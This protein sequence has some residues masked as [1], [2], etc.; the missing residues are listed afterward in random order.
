M[1]KT[2]RPILLVSLLSLLLVMAPSLRA[3]GH[4]EFSAHYGQWSLNLLGGLARDLISDATKS[5]IR[6]RIL[7]NIQGSYPGLNETSYNQTVRFDSS[8]H[9]FGFGVRFYPSRNGSFSLGVSV[10]QSTFKV[11]PSVTSQMGLQDSGT[12]QT[13]TFDGTAAASAVIKATAFLLTFRWDIF[14]RA[15]VHPYITFG[16]GITTAKAL[17]DSTLSYSYSGQL[18][19]GAVT[20]QTISGSDSKTLRQLKDQS[21]TKFPNFL[22]FLQLNFGLKAMVTK[23]IHLLVDAGVFDGFMISGGLAVRL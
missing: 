7:S 19:G 12:S 1:K 13:A 20:P 11:L 15:V 10:E 8:G 2:A 16:G 23:N 5:E 14:P 6:D 18:A 22:P 4:F 9:D 3:Q 21:D 17:D